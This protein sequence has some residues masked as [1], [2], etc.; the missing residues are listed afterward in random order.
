[1]TGSEAVVP[2]KRRD[3]TLCAGKPSNLDPVGSRVQ[4]WGEGVVRAALQ[5]S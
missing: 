5:A 1:M 4:S 3:L 2:E